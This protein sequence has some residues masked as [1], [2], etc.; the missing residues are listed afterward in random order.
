MVFY[1]D[2]KLINYSTAK[3]IPNGNSWPNLAIIYLKRGE[4]C[5][6]IV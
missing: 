6:N 1:L 2:D 5:T 4:L 3:I